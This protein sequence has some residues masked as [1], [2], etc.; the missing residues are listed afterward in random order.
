VGFG[1]AEQPQGDGVAGG[2]GAGMAAMG[3]IVP[4]GL[5]LPVMITGPESR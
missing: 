3:L 1:V 4:P 2:L 5:V